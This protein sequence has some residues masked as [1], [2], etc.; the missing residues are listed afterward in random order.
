MSSS[1]PPLVTCSVSFEG[2][3]ERGTGRAETRAGGEFVLVQG[4]RGISHRQ[5][6]ELDENEDLALVVVEGVEELVEEP[7]TFRAFGDA[8]RHLRRR[9]YRFEIGRLRVERQ[10]FALL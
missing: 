10:A 5:T 8:E 7:H 3:L 2:P 6:F 4:V 9:G 1:E